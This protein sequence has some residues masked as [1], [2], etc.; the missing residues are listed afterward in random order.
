MGRPQTPPPCT[1]MPHRPRG[2]GAATR[3]LPALV[4]PGRSRPACMATTPA[5][6]GARKVRSIIVA[7]GPPPKRGNVRPA[8]RF[9][10]AEGSAVDVDPALTRPTRFAP[11]LAVPVPQRGPGLSLLGCAGPI[12]EETRQRMHDASVRVVDRKGLACG[13]LRGEGLRVPVQHH[14]LA[15]RRVRR[16]HL[17]QLV[18]GEVVMGLDPLDPTLLVP[19]TRS[20]A[21]RSFDGSGTL[22]VRQDALLVHRRPPRVG[23]ARIAWVSPSP[24][25]GRQP[26]EEEERRHCPRPR[27][28]K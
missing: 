15:V 8:H 14:K 4:L 20:L 1:S 26:D 6:G 24:G 25:A 9:G 21:S 27:S 18:H 17:H 2:S 5:L 3:S 11:Q 22:R 28:C 23:R 19:Y 12:A 10:V 13:D 7:V 16:A